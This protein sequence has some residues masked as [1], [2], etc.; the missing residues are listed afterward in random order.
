MT[1]ITERLSS[2]IADRYV[3]ERELGQGG[4]ATVYLAHDVKHDRKVALKVL[5]PELAA[6]IGAERFLQEIKVT[7]NLQH[8]HI[9]P[10][11]DSGAAEGFL[12]YVMP[13]VEGETLRTL[14]AREKQLGVDEAVDLAC[15]VASALEHAHKQ[16]VV[17][18]DIKPD[19]ILMRDGDPVVADFGI[20]LALSHAGGT[21]LTETGL[22]IGTPQYMSPEQAMGERE[23]TAKS[24]VYALGCVLYEM[25]TGEPPFVG[26]TAQAIIARVITE[27]PRPL[28][29][30][31][32]TVPEHVAEAVHKALNKLPADR[33]HTAA[34][35]GHALSLRTSTATVPGRSVPRIRIR[36]P[37]TPLVWALTLALVAMTL[38]AAWSLTSRPELPVVHMAMG[39]PPEQAM[40]YRGIN[41]TPPRVAI[42]PNGSTIIY[43]GSGP[44]PAVLP[45]G[46]RAFRGGQFA[47]GVGSQLWIRPLNELQ[48]LPIAG[49]EMGWAPAISPDGSRF[50]FTVFDEGRADIKVAPVAGG[51]LLTVA[52]LSA[53]SSASWGPDDRVYFIDA[54]GRGVLSVPAG[55]GP[56]DTVT[57]LPSFPAG[58]RVLWPHVLPD[59]RGAIVT[60]GLQEQSRLSTHK[61][62]VVDFE[63][64]T[65]RLLVEGAYGLYSPSGHLLYV[66]SENV[67]MAVPFD[68]RSREITGRPTALVEG[69]DFRNNGASDLAVSTTGSLVYSTPGINAPEVMVQVDRFGT[70][71]PVDPDWTGNL[72]FEGMALSPDGTRLAVEL[73]SPGRARAEIWIKRLP[74]GPLSRLTFEGVDNHAPTWSPDGSS[75]VYLSRTQAGNWLLFQRPADGSG[76]AEPL[77]T[78]EREMHEVIWSSD[79]AWLLGSVSG[80]P[81]DDIVARRVDGDTAWTVV[82][83]GPADEF[84]P[85]LSPSGRWL[86][87]VSEESGQ[88]EIYI[89]PFPNTSSG[90]WQISTGGG[91]EPLW[92]NTDRELYYRSFD[93][94]TVWEASLA[95]GPSAAVRRVAIEIEEG[96]YEANPRNRLVVRTPDG[97]RFLMINQTGQGDVSGDMVFVQNFFAHLRAR[98]RQ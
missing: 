57:V 9:L 64:G 63:A 15:K 24:D 65:S 6:V 19:N 12:F 70:V 93:G 62:H 5:R 90:K 36:L 97:Q 85:A 68:P 81:S 10:L 16:G 7:A 80:P 46:G 38:V 98:S 71:E 44:T 40:I 2:A 49:T 67:L 48:G 3:I 23:I 43:A 50:V 30:Q 27:D 22:S 18:R 11:Y 73:V 94:M 76:T 26:P 31:R 29:L 21:R 54:S 20:A 47:L 84:E 75:L 52:S 33:F 45:G 59:G 79:G 92:G 51:P 32:R 39:L 95:N 77:P 1:E 13:Y 86:A 91:I 4:M 8:S 55:G 82:V 35:F 78:P 60:V 28:L 89:R 61:I 66:T 14:L 74:R 88:A 72:E 37:G 41:L 17:H 53:F 42:T 83:D 96:V 56:V 58:A 69:V 34:E 25:L 87:Y